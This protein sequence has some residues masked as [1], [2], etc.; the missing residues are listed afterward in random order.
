MA[1]NLNL[2][3]DLTTQNSVF[4]YPTDPH[5]HHSTRKALT[6]LHGK[7][8][9]STD[10]RCQNTEFLGGNLIRVELENRV[11]FLHLVD[12]SVN[13]SIYSYLFMTPQVGYTSQESS[14]SCHLSTRTSLPGD[15]LFSQHSI[16]A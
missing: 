10:L 16:A 12:F 11:L 7:T 8:G 3:H 15:P 1:F 2:S 9:K 5:P 13:L 6:A 4:P 14:F